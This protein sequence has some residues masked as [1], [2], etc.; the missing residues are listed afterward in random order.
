MVV[1]QKDK[2]ENDQPNDPARLVIH[3]LHKG[4]RVKT[5]GFLANIARH[6]SG[7]S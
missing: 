3:A 4:L 6:G 7:L 5:K 2:L 1:P